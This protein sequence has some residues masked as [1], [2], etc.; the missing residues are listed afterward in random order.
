[1]SSDPDYNTLSIKSVHLFLQTLVTEITNRDEYITCPCKN[2][3]KNL[4]VVVKKLKVLSK[5]AKAKTTLKIQL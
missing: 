2:I 5:N 3:K 1:M 4:H